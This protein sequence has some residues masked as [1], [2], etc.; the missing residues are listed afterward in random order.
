MY[1]ESI[2]YYAHIADDLLRR[3][4]QRTMFYGIPCTLYEMIDSQMTT[5]YHVQ[6]IFIKYMK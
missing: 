2:V 5:Y 1:R 3:N 6:R 4:L